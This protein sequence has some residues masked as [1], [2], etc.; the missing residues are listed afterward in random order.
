MTDFKFLQGYQPEMD[1]INLD[2]P[3]AIR[4]LQEFND[5]VHERLIL[6]LR[7]PR[8]YLDELRNIN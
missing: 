3:S 5:Y 1:I 8:Q 7:I 6:G 2:L 4:E